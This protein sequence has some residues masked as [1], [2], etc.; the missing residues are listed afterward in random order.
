MNEYK[1]WLFVYTVC[2]DSEQWNASTAHTS[3]LYFF[4][5][6]LINTME[7][8]GFGFCVSTEQVIN[9]LKDYKE[10]VVHLSTVYCTMC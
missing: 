10:D 9:I 7:L 8:K 6:S 4:I 3:L 5:Y 1:L 2:V